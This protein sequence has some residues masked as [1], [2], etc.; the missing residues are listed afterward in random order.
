[1]NK[2]MNVLGI[3]G[4][5]AVS[6]FL[7]TTLFKAG[8]LKSKQPKPQARQTVDWDEEKGLDHF[9]EALKIKT[10]SYE[11][12]EQIQYHEFDRFL[13]FLER[14]YPH[15]HKNLS[16]EKI[17]EYALV[18]KWK[19]TDSKSLPIG[20]ISHYDVVPVPEE[21]IKNWTK[22]P[23][24]GA[25]HENI[26]WGRGTLDDKIGVIGILE[27]AEALLKKGFQPTRDLY[28][29]FGFDE[30]IGGE[31]GAKSIV[32]ILK[33]R[34]I[35][36]DFV[37]DEGGAII[38]GMLPGVDKPVGVIGVSEK[39]IAT[40]ELSLEGSG[41]HASQPKNQTNIGRISKAIA[42]LEKRQFPARLQEPTTSL[43]EYAAPEMTGIM[44]YIVANQKLFKPI[45]EKTLV[46]N[47]TMAALLR[48]TIA[49]TVFLSGEK[50]NVLPESATAT[51]NLRLMPGD[52]LEYV[53][54]FIEETI[55]DEEIQVT[56]SGSEATKV[57]DVTGWQ[58]EA[59]QQAT[60]NIYPETIVTPYLMFAGSDARYYDQ[61][62]DYTFRFLPAHITSKDLN[63]IHGTNEQ[64]SV[65]NYHNVVYFYLELMNRL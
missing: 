39:G 45:L 60:K 56:I 41:G 3:A 46:K 15:V 4:V 64:I 61:I 40:V 20:L 17:N 14:A 19:G 44:K 13:G 18:Y 10:V 33:K 25:V 12:K 37:L 49:P 23:F 55:Q 29:M 53:R 31:L 24:S 59:I 8:K 21:T 52:S 65:E 2:I 36:F 28:L 16:L 32:E 54:Q 11:Q 27:A 1:M 63:R 9:S 26:I 7:G 38:D 35:Q 43:L 51:I 42:A 22:D 57:S 30:E 48:T 5:V 62:A 34:N 47:P 6:S 58:F 50:I